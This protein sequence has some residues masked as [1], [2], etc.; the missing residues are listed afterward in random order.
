VSGEVLARVRAGLDRAPLAG[1]YPTGVAMALLGLCPFIVLTTAFTLLSRH[2][3]ADLHTSMFAANLSNGLSNAGY[4]FGAVSAADLVLRVPQRWLYIGCEAVFVAGSLLAATAPGIGAFTAGR[5]AQGVTTG[6]LLVVALPPLVTNYGAGKLPLSGLFV[7]LGLF[8]M[9][10]LG[11]LAG[12]LT[13]SFGD[14]RW[15]FAAVAGL[16]VVGLLVGVF[17]YGPSQAPSPRVGFDL[18][19]VPLALGATFLPFFAVS[20]LTV[21]GYISAGFLAPLLLGLG[22]L[23]A[24][25]GGQF[26]KKRALVPVGPISNT[27]PIVGIGVACIGGAIFTVLLELIVRYLTEVLHYAPALTGGLLA[28]LLI[29][30]AGGSVLFKRMLPGR[31]MPV[32]A[33][34]GLLA[35]G[36]AAAMLLGLTAGNAAV[37]V[38]VAAVLLGFGAGAAVAPGLFMGG[39]SVPSTKI[40][41]TFALVELLRSEAAFILAPVLAYVAATS[42]SSLSAGIHLATGIAF[43]LLAIVAPLLVA[44]LLLG[45]V[46]PHRPDLA[47]WLAGGTTAYHSP[48][49]AAAFR[50]SARL[51]PDDPALEIPGAGDGGD[52]GTS[53]P[54]A[55]APAAAAAAGSSTVD[56]RITRDG[57]LAGHEQP[58]TVTVLDLTGAPAGW[59]HTSTDGSYRLTGLPAGTHTLVAAAPGYHP[60]TTRVELTGATRWN[61]TLA[62]ADG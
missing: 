11:P 18:T 36:V 16:G 39:L 42:L 14:W 37:M 52:T 60:T 59:A 26:A 1:R 34:S 32:L 5:V 58:A 62:R 31:W 10:T 49:L 45:G 46:G 24:L 57:S 13:A 33:L 51:W 30:I 8:G 22:L 4:A 28:P 54:S 2:I 23:V 9:V 43:G 53:P 7:N 15:L 3:V 40:G 41:P 56:G 55:D 27:L 48:A 25:V 20:W 50:Q 44:V 12:G 35:V 47:G 29:G 17:S 21:G 38:P 61:A 6:I 19:A